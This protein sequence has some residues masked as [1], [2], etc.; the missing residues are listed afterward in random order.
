[1]KRFYRGFDSI[2]IN[3]VCT[4]ILIIYE[5]MCVRVNVSSTVYHWYLYCFLIVCVYV[6]V[7]T[8]LCI[9]SGIYK[10]R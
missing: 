9:F 1:M 6:Y 10:N 2:V 3:S 4:K 8:H 5:C 7:C